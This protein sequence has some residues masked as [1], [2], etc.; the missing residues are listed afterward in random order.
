[1]ASQSR[2]L[3]HWIYGV[4]GTDDL[5]GPADDAGVDV[6]GNGLAPLDRKDVYGTDVNTCTAAIAFFQVDLDLQ[7]PYLTATLFTS[8]PLRMRKAPSGVTTLLPK[9][10]TRSLMIG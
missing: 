5:T 7:Y 8:V 10:T 2:L 1:M 3:F 4:V 9:S 6:H